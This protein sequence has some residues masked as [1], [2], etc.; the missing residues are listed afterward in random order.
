MMSTAVMTAPRSAEALGEAVERAWAGP[1]P[2]ARC[3]SPRVLPSA[4]PAPV[5]RVVGQHAR[6]A[7]SMIRITRSAPWPCGQCWATGWSGM[8]CGGAHVTLHVRGVGEQH[9]VAVGDA[10]VELA[11]LGAESRVERGDERVGFGLGD[12]AGGEVRHQPVGDGHEVAAEDELV[13][14]GGQALAAASRGA[15]PE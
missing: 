11:A 8:S 15:R 13:G 10:G 6:R 12:V 4:A 3:W 2:T 5:D 1:G 9:E 14:A 7:R